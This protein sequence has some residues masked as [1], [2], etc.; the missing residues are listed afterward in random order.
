MIY[1]N[2]AR[3]GTCYS[4]MQER[5]DNKTRYKI[6]NAKIVES[7]FIDAPYDTKADAKEALESGVTHNCEFC[8]PV[9][10]CDRLTTDNKMKN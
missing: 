1:L 10:G 4:S 2:S 7:M 3:H 9:S 5:T 6:E 8:Y